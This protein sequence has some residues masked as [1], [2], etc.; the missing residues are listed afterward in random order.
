[1]GDIRH[2]NLFP[3][4]TPTAAF[5]YFL[6]NTRRAEFPRKVDVVH[7][8]IRELNNDFKVLAGA[9]EPRRPFGGQR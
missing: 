8:T 3:L 1:M 9:A 4:D 7:L 2:I 6:T 5:S